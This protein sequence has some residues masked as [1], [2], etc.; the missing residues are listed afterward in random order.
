MAP[1]EFVDGAEDAAER[2]EAR[3]SDSSGLPSSDE[4]ASAP[5]RIVKAIRKKPN[6]AFSTPGFPVASRTPPASHEPANSPSAVAA[7]PSRPRKANTVA[8]SCSGATKIAS[9]S[10]TV[11]W[12]AA[13]TH[14]TSSAA[15]MNIPMPNA[16]NPSGIGLP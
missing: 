5:I 8:I 10:P 11:G 15:Y 1:A 4:T 14:P 16:K 7:P 3:K 2:R 12:S 9:R 6:A 13:F